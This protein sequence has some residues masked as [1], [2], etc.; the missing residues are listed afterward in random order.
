M[1][2]FINLFLLFSQSVNKLKFKTVFLR[3]ILAGVKGDVNMFG[4][5]SCFLMT[6]SATNDPLLVLSCCN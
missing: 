1:T 6:F 5:N 3:N 4:C 2:R